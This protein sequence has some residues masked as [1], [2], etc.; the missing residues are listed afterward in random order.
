MIAYEYEELADMSMIL[1]ELDTL[2]RGGYDY[3]VKKLLA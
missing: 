1:W 3:H 2:V